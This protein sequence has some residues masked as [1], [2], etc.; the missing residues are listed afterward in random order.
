MTATQANG[1]PEAGSAYT[2]DRLAGLK[3]M[4]VEVLG[5]QVLVRAEASNCAGKKFLIP[6]K[7]FGTKLRRV[8]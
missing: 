2:A 3:L 7:H 4:V 5:E 1:K 6:L 8:A